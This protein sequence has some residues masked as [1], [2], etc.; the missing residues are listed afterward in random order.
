M[1]SN[2]IALIILVI[3]AGACS[4][5]TNSVWLDDLPIQTFSEGIRPVN[6]K[7]SYGKDTIRISG[8]SYSRGLGAITPCV[9]AFSLDGKAKHFSAEVGPDD[10]GNKDIPLTFFVVGDE[11]V[12]FESPEMRIGDAPVPVDIDLTG[13]KQL[14]LLVTDPVGGVGNK[15]TYVNWANAKIEMVG[16]AMPGYVTIADE[17]YILTPAPKPEPKINSAKRFGATPGNPFLYTIAATGNRPMQ[18]SA[19]NLPSGLI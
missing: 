15:R 10:S 1:K 19:E 13:I 5:K 8:K 3:I 12:L 9:L 7:I 11:K 16:S 14:G 2:L 18:F 17:K 6:A 4:Q